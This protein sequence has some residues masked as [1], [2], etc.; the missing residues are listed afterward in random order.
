MSTDQDD[1]PRAH[2][3]R[4]VKG[5]L[6]ALM[7]EGGPDAKGNKAPDGHVQKEAL[8][9]FGE[10]A[11]IFIHLL[12]STAN[13]IC[14]DGKR[15][16]I[17]VDDVFKA[18][19]ELEFSEFGEPLK[20]ALAAFKKDAA[21]KSAKRNDAAIKKRKAEDDAVAEGGEGGDD[22]EEPAEEGA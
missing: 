22:E 6:T 17:S 11:K 12:T 8:L 10:C 20:E 3:K 9:A 2:I 4:I 21:A 16:T 19:D 5:K 13:D 18:V 15:Q 1:L 7:N 14:R